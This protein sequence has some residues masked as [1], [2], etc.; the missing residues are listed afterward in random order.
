MRL[1]ELERIQE[2]QA[3]LRR[4]EEEA[5]KAM[6]KLKEQEEEKPLRCRLKK[7][8]INRPSPPK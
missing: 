1:Q 7:K 4:K 6:H 3:K 8:S 5:T 2:Q